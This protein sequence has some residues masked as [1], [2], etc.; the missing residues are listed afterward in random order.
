MRNFR[1][2]EFECRHVCSLGLLAMLGHNTGTLTP[3]SGLQIC[4]SIRSDLLLVI[5][6]MKLEYG[7]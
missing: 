6:M 1:G 7:Y 5:L 3:W 4:E 2:H